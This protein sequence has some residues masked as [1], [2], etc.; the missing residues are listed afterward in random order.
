MCE[1]LESYYEHKWPPQRVN[2]T[3]SLD[4]R[5]LNPLPIQYEASWLWK[6]NARLSIC[7]FGTPLTTQ[8][9]TVYCLP[10]DQQLP[11]TWTLTLTQS[12]KHTHSWQ[13]LCTYYWIKTTPE[14]QQT[15]SGG[16]KSVVREGLLF[17]MT[18]YDP[19]PL[20]HSPPHGTHLE[21]LQKTQDSRLT[22]IQDWGLHLPIEKRVPTFTVYP[23]V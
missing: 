14:S 18:H 9:K 16:Y 21:C 12:N 13:L 1:Y 7:L 15:D 11:N 22:E 4:Y 10:T 3:I 19:Y 17:D 20:T 8:W 23:S 2:V 6:N 5:I